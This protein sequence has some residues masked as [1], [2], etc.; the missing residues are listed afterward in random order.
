MNDKNKH[1]DTDIGGFTKAIG[2]GILALVTAGGHHVSKFFRAVE[3]PAIQAIEHAG[4]GVKSAF[5]A[6][7]QP[8]LEAF[9]HSG[10]RSAREAASDFETAMAR[11]ARPTTDVALFTA[12]FLARSEEVGQ[13]LTLLKFK[14]PPVIYHRLY[15]QWQQNHAEIEACHQQ[16]QSPS[17]SPNERENAVERLVTATQRN[18]EI[19]RLMAQYG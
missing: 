11:G 16:L 15:Q 1:S 3:N 17:L 14:I 8:A 18:A 4:G 2:V 13:R 6:V 9:E 5:R 7:E 12:Q 10:S 19:E